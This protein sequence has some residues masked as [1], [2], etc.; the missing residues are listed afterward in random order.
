M[1][2][3][4]IRSPVYLVYTDVAADGAT[5]LTK[6][7]TTECTFILGML[8]NWVIFQTSF[9]FYRNSTISELNDAL[10]LKCLK[11]VLVMLVNGYKKRSSNPL[12]NFV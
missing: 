8:K 9:K 3:A 12:N 4:T 1:F 7:Q 5:I 6:F 11:L 2:Q 10:S